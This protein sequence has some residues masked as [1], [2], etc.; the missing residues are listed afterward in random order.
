MGQNQSTPSTE[1]PYHKRHYTATN[2]Q[3]QR[4]NSISLTSPAHTLLQNPG[5]NPLRDYALKRAGTLTM[6]SNSTQT[7]GQS[8]S[9]VNLHSATIGGG[10]S[11]V[12]GFGGSGVTGDNNNNNTGATTITE[13]GD[14]G[15]RPFI[16]LL[17]IE[18]PQPVYFDES[19][20]SEEDYDYEDDGGD[21]EY[22]DEH[23]DHTHSRHNSSSHL[24]HRNQ[25]VHPH[26]SNDYSDDDD[27]DLVEHDLY[28]HRS[29][30]N[31][32]N[33][34][35]TNNR[36]LASSPSYLDSSALNG[37]TNTS[38][39]D[40]YGYE[41]SHHYHQRQT[42]EQADYRRS[43]EEE[44]EDFSYLSPVS[45]QRRFAK[46]TYPRGGL[47]SEPYYPAHHLDLDHEHHPHNQNLTDT[48]SDD[49][50]AYNEELLL[51]RYQLRDLPSHSPSGDAT[52]NIVSQLDVKSSASITTTESTRSPTT[53]STLILDAIREEKEQ[54]D[55]E[56]SRISPSHA[57]TTFSHPSKRAQG[58]EG[59]GG[60]G[61]IGGPVLVSSSNN[62]L[63]EKSRM[64]YS[65]DSTQ[66]LQEANNQHNSNIK[67]DARSLPS[68]PRPC[69]LISIKDKDKD[70]DKDRSRSKREVKGEEE[71]EELEE[72]GMMANRSG[73]IWT[74]DF[75][76]RK[77]L[78]TTNKVQVLHDGQETSTIGTQ[79][80]TIATS[81]TAHQDNTNT[82][83]TPLPLM[84]FAEGVQ[85]DSSLPVTS[86]SS[87]QRTSQLLDKATLLELRLELQAFGMR[88]HELNDSLLTDLMTQMRQ[89]KLMLFES[90]TTSSSSSSFLDPNG[91]ALVVRRVDSVEAEMHARLLRDIETRIQDRVLAMEQTSARLEK[92]FD[93]M[94]ARLGAL[95]IILVAGAAGAGTGNGTAGAT[96]TTTVLKR[97]RPES[98][99][100]I[101]Q[102]QQQLQLQ[103]QQLQREQEQ[104]ERLRSQQQQ[105]QQQQ[106]GQGQGGHGL[107]FTTTHPRSSD[108]SPE[109]PTPD[110]F[111]SPPSSSSSTPL[112]RT[113]TTTGFASQ[114]SSSSSLQQDHNTHAQQ[115]AQQESSQPLSHTSFNNALLPFPPPPRLQ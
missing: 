71:V 82:N 69:R 45:G 3:I 23:S 104:Q 21:G 67:G 59:E 115:P 36:G 63:K 13:G 17:P 86:T 80:T 99:Y 88:F 28:G 54:S 51:K 60:E 77:R 58:E 57:S 102:Q 32:N 40:N 15:A 78:Y 48:D 9:T 64:G 56:D 22:S 12:G 27:D 68:T 20:A 74:C 76:T 52:D 79:D 61:G 34:N 33:I 98:M 39:S 83:T 4:Q 84:S 73:P 114:S 41:H 49:D 109:S 106:Q 14:E 93:Q 55:E 75:F 62:S 112:P 16:R 110:K 30:S 25:H 87:L 44:E 65:L 97:P 103:Q 91:S 90:T 38:S 53:T 42:R 8:S 29:K 5:P 72:S 66:P 26:H 92:C 11:G 89:A 7:A 100:K 85:P 1:E 107:G 96:T 105:Q 101:L 94:E 24:R 108:S 113:I 10:G 37:R 6:Q 31:N 35:N 47:H 81:T 46:P 2:R 50:E 19:S 111:Q 70:K 43:K 18:I 95:E